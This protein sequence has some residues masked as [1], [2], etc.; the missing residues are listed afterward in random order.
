LNALTAMSRRALER[1]RQE[2][3]KLVEEASRERAEASA[4]VEPDWP[5]R[6][7]NASSAAVLS[8][9]GD[10][11][12]DELREIEDALAR[13]DAGTW[14]RCETCGGAIGRQRLMALPEARQCLSC[15][16]QSDRRISQSR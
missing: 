14:G 11:E 16:S 4:E 6:A 2:L 10:M 5:D 8:R 13:I 12:Q 1:R 3:L 15:R 9:L 7:S